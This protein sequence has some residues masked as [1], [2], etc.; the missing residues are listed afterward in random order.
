MPSE[1]FYQKDGTEH[2]PISS[3]ALR[4]LVAGAQINP[5]TPLRRSEMAKWARAGAVKGLFPDAPQNPAPASLD[6]AT[7]P[8]LQSM[9]RT[10]PTKPAPTPPPLPVS[11][12]SPAPSNKALKIVAGAAA[13]IVSFAGAWMLASYVTS[14]IA[15]PRQVVGPP[16]SPTAPV[17]AFE[18]VSERAAATPPP[19]FASDDEM[20]VYTLSSTD[21]VVRY[22]TFNLLQ[23]KPNLTP[24]QADH[25]ASLCRDTLSKQ[26][27]HEC[28][29][30]ALLVF[31]LVGNKDDATLAESMAS[32]NIPGVKANCLM[33]VLILNPDEGVK[34]ADAHPDPGD[35]YDVSALRSGLERDKNK[36]GLPA[37]V[38]LLNAGHPALRGLGLQVIQ[39]IGTAAQIP[40]V[41]DALTQE[42]QNDDLKSKEQWL[43]GYL[44]SR[45]K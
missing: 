5:D 36:R 21:P 3:S 12:E 39:D 6:A 18:S 22:T 26:D 24:V 45:P 7:T 29:Y 43:V 37:A 38:A 8:T 28:F 2:G 19:T 30:N 13:F 35:F 34:F 40:A 20:I 17:S 1:W 41:Q 4:Q 27:Y 23:K 32:Q 31:S 44:K 15:H 33:A 16:P 42:K 9:P 14:R 25:A 11:A 10:A